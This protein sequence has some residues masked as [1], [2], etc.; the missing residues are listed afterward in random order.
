MTVGRHSRYYEN[1]KDSD[2][3]DQV[4]QPYPHLTSDA[5]ATSL[6]HQE[7][8]QHHLTDWDFT[9]LRAEANAML[10]ECGRWRS[11]YQTADTTAAP[12]LEVHY[13]SSILE[14]EAEMDVRSQW[15]NVEAKS[16]GLS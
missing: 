7:L 5:Q 4:I 11:A 1:L 16:W 14:F 6:Q 13:G 3:F 15:K 10:G 9:L 2:L 12:V 8:V